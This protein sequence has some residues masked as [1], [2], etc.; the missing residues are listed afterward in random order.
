VSQVVSKVVRTKRDPCHSWVMV[1]AGIAECRA[2]LTERGI[3]G[4]WDLSWGQWRTV[5]R[6]KGVPHHRYPHLVLLSLEGG[7]KVL[8]SST[9]VIWALE[10]QEPS[11]LRTE[12][13]H[14]S[15]HDWTVSLLSEENLRFCAHQ[16]LEVRWWACVLVW[17]HR[18]V[19]L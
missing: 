12:P 7:V 11:A 16:A 17:V 13:S 6:N 14:V 10:S 18:E 4:Q 9:V 1:S 3:V 19:E 2:T 8:V 5:S 15:L